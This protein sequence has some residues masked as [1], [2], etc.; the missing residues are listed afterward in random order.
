MAEAARLVDRDGAGS[1]TLRAV[2]ERF[3]V[4]QPS[5][6][7]HIGGL[8]DLH[9]RLALVAA[10]EL[11]TALRTAV[12]G[13]AGAEATA[14]VATAYRRYATEHPGCYAY[15][16][17][18]RADDA[19]HERASAEVLAVLYAVLD[20]YDI[21]EEADRVDAARFLRSAMHGFVALELGGGYAMS[22]S[23]DDS[24]AA[25]LRAVDLALR[26]WTASVAV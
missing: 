2:A 8:E 4:A 11:G 16:L 3:G 13:R 18:P 24:F 19:D 25:T 9:G 23:V 20:G 1:L 12:S 7:K 14:A 5:L 26:G 21:R 15:L 22:R 10:R 17:R 6:Y